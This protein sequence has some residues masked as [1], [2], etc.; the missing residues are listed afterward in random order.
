VRRL[1]VLLVL[2]PLVAAACGGSASDDDAT[3]PPA[4]TASAASLARATERTTA[5]GSARFTLDVAAS[6][7]GAAIQTQSRGSVSFRERRAH[8]FKLVPGI[9]YPQEEIVDGPVIYRNS[10]VAGALSDPT[11]K[12]WTKIDTRRLPAAQ[13]LAEL[14]HVRAL[15]YLPAGARSSQRIGAEGP[16]T[17]FRGQVDRDRVLAHVPEEQRAVIGAVLEAD[18]GGDRFPADFWLDG[19]S[20]LRRVRVAYS[21]P[22]GS[23]FELVG[24]FSGFGSP[25]DVTP[26]P[27]RATEVVA[28]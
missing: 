8:V 17:H 14:D 6:L 4:P 10:N 5:D 13:Q 28:P 12:P 24:T 11:L 9:P 27:A 20:R 2:V 18:Y 15:A 3:A 7:R 23:R 25:V 21:T 26:P 1:L 19:K 16:L 22:Q